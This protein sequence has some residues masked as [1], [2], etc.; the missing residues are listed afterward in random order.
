MNSFHAWKWTGLCFCSFSIGRCLG[1]LLRNWS[2][3]KFVAAIVTLSV[4]QPLN[5]CRDIFFFTVGLGLLEQWVFAS[6]F[7]I[8]LLHC[9]SKRVSLIAPALLSLSLPAVFYCYLLFKACYL[10]RSWW[11]R[12]GCFFC[13]F[14]PES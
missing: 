13:C 8:Y 4:P 12:G 2:G 5:S 3:F 9:A 11:W 6:D 1:E 10:Q 14:K 7:C